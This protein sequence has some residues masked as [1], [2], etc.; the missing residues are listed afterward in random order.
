V[1]RTVEARVA[2]VRRLLACARAVH[3]QRARIAPAI[4][5]ASGLTAQG[6]ELGFASL[7]REATDRD[8]RALVVSA[9]DTRHVHVVLSANVFVAP[10]RALAIARAASERVTVRPSPRDPALTVALLEAAAS[11][12][13]DAFT[14]VDQRDVLPIEAGEV[15]V[16]G[17]DA[18]IAAVRTR[19]RRG[20]V[21]RGHAAG[22]GMALVSPDGDLG[23]AAEALALDVVTFDQR[24][25]LSP[26]VAMVLGNEGRAEQ[27]GEAL[28]AAFGRWEVRVPRGRLLEDERVEARRWRETVAFAGRL[29]EGHDWA[30]AVAGEGAS[31]SIPPPGRHVTVVAVASADSVAA[32]IAPMAAGIVAVG[33]DAPGA[34]LGA[35]LPSHARLSALGAMQR[36]PLDGPVDRRLA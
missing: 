10:L 23:A 13:D 11:A 32:A 17:R 28:H 20:V 33:T 29:R 36:P 22:M 31:F 16:Y 15:H 30:V 2:D 8:L 1:S 7:E 9:G 14:R 26:R 5:A 12:G 25:C 34:K 4:A 3:D 6:V 24:G 35:R 27:F 19:V 18:T 21:V